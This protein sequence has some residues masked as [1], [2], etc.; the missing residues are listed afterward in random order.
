MKI[1]IACD[2]DTFRNPYVRTLAEGMAAFDT[3]I[4]C[5]ISAF[6][7]RWDLYDIIHIQWPN[8]LLQNRYSPQQLKDHLTT[9]KKA[10]KIIVVTCHNYSPHYRSSSNK[11]ESYE[12]VYNLADC[13]VHLGSCSYDECKIRYPHAK[14]Y[15]IPHHVYDK[16][17]T[18]IPSRSEAVRHLKLDP[19]KRYIICFGAFRHDEERQIAQK[20]AR[21]VRNMNY[22]VLAPGFSR[23]VLRKRFWVSAKQYIRYV[24][25]KIKYGDIVFSKGFVPDEE[26][27]YY[28]AASDI[29]LI[30]RKKILN[31]GNLPMAFYMGK[32]TV[33]PD[34]GN[35]GAI[36]KETD[37]PVFDTNNIDS[38][39]SAIKSALLL[40]EK[41][42]GNENKAFAEKHFLTSVIAEQH[43]N[44]YKILLN[45]S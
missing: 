22:I 45:E 25:R 35:V 34:I 10:G 20:A 18:R 4:D 41:G 3:D 24:V 43:I 17:Y 28:Y 31:S 40:F 32:V 8:V 19:S 6:W 15:V 39:S 13:F 16:L 29:A 14:H 2:K 27:P 11:T 26:L 30:H 36:L 37:N 12:I 42:K 1:L 44:I 33:G 23:I 7:Q 5:S 9:V 21:I 38:L